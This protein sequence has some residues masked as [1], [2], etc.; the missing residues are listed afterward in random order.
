MSRCTTSRRRRVGAG[1]SHPVASAWECWRSSPGCRFA[2]GPRASPPAR[3]R[4]ADR[5]RHAASLSRL[6]R[7]CSRAPMQGAERPGGNKR[8]T[9]KRSSIVEQLLWFRPRVSLSIDGGAIWGE[10]GVSA[11]APPEAR[12][13]SCRPV[14]TAGGATSARTAAVKAFA[15][16]GGSAEPARSAAVP[17]SASTGGSAEPARSAAAAASASTGGCAASARIAGAAASASTGGGAATARSVAAAASA[18]TGGCAASAKSAAA[19]ASASTGG[20]AASAKTAAA[21]ASASTAG[22][23]GGARSAAAKASASTGAGAAP[24]RTAAAA[25]VT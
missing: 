14:L 21:A 24:A 6:F 22:N 11:C 12:G 5:A 7:V 18:S 15:S 23:A 19:N 8:A 9:R 16:T 20:S 10:S 25:A 17:A 4:S 1:Y 13:E 3:P 2:F